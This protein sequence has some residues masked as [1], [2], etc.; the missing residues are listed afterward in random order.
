MELFLNAT[1]PYAR[2]VRIVALEKGLGDAV[3][4]RWCDP[5]ANDEALL[6][7]NPVGRVPALVTGDGQALG[8]SLLIAQY[9]DAVGD[10][11][12][13]LPSARQTEMLALAGL[14]QGLMDA[15]FHTVIARK[16]HGAEADASVLGQRRRRAIARTLAALEESLADGERAPGF[17]PTR[18]TLGDIV[19]VVALDYLAFRLPEIAWPQNL[20]RLA[21]WHRAVIARD[22]FLSTRFS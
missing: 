6:I 14:G 7:A 19:V 9:L 3:T 13:L 12:P 5:W 4:L 16:H 15:A 22:S 11:E 1:S 2:V 10:G 18:I 20:P 8:E 21:D 17:D